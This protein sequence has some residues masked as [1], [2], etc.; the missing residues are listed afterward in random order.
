L[1]DNFTVLQPHQRYEMRI[2]YHGSGT[3]RLDSLTVTYLGP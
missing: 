2:S 3:L 1:T